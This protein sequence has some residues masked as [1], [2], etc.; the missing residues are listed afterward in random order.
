[1]TFGACFFYPRYFGSMC[2]FCYACCHCA[3]WS[4]ILGVRFNP[5]GIYC[6]YNTAPT[7]YD[8]DVPLNFNRPDG[9]WHFDKFSDETTYEGEAGT[10]AGLGVIQSILW[11]VQCCCCCLPLLYT[12]VGGDKDKDK[13]KDKKNKDMQQQMYPGAALGQ[14]A[15]NQ[16]MQWQ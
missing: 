15:D 8:P 12:P 4:M 5:F 14:P 9:T 16:Q 6:S 10:L 7:K 11:C 1:M 13:K 2:N 3:A